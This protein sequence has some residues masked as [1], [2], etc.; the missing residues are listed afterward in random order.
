MNVVATQ[1]GEDAEEQSQTE[2]T[3]FGAYV[4]FVDDYPQ[5]MSELL[6]RET[7]EGS[8]DVPQVGTSAVLAINQEP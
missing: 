1:H 5:K 3:R 8:R 7:P 2:S 4:A 6:D